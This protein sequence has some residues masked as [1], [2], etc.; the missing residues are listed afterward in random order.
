[1]GVLLYETLAGRPP[2]PVNT[3]SDALRIVITEPPPPLLSLRGDLPEA[4][5]AVILQ[6]LEKEPAARYETAGD[7]AQALAEVVAHMANL[8]TQPDQRLQEGQ[9]GQATITDLPHQ[10][11]EDAL[12]KA[13][14]GAN[15]DMLELSLPGGETRS[16]PL[17]A[18]FTIGR[19]LDNDLVLSDGKV[20]RHHARIEQSGDRYQVIDLGSANGTTLGAARLVPN[21]LVEW[22]PSQT[23]HIGAAVLRLRLG[24]RSTA[25][26]ETIRP[27][28]RQKAPEVE[29]QQP[30]APEPFD[31]LARFEN[32]LLTAPCIGYVVVENKDTRTAL[33]RINLRS[34][35]DALLIEPAEGALRL[36]PGMQNSF[37]FTA[38]PKVQPAFGK[39]KSV[40]FGARVAA[41]DGTVQTL[42]GTAAISP[43]FK[44]WMAALAVGL[45]L[46]FIFACILLIRIF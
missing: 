44:A 37:S 21:N 38:R 25:E 46:L 1:L 8:P 9:T 28:I 14:P 20:S 22:H 3:L 45:F 17:H 2:F 16:L 34:K 27:T 39:V 10:A 4:L 19:E 15:L 42:Q 26:P 6:A 41:Q 32:P 23:V 33:F 30:L 31:F 43:H 13:Q 11:V 18:G 40:S 24:G 36:T 5:E 7:F 35:S 29:A 12:K